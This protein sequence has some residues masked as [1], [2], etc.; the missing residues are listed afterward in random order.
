MAWVVYHSVDPFCSKES[1][2]LE[3][4]I[5]VELGHIG[6]IGGKGASDTLCSLRIYAA[7]SAVVNMSQ[8]I[9][10]ARTRVVVLSAHL[11]GCQTPNGVAVKA[12]V[13]SVAH[14]STTPWQY[15]I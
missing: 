2:F 3:M 7:Q 8:E 12:Q 15:R 4:H 5:A 11:A 6:Y 1:L 14:S 9:I 10:N 13:N